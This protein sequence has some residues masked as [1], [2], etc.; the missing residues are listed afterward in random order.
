MNVEW[1]EHLKVIRQ[2]GHLLGAIEA[3]R[4]LTKS[5]ED[6]GYDRRVQDGILYDLAAEVHDD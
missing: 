6:R 3:H 1:E 2:V 4:I 5:D